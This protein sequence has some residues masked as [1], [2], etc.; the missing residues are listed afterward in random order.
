[1][2]T[3]RLALLDYRAELGDRAEP[4]QEW[5]SYITAQQIDLTL[6]AFI[7]VLAVTRVQFLP[8][9]RFDFDDEG[10]PAAVCEVL[11]DDAETVIDL[12]AWSVTKPEKFGVALGIAAGLG[13]DQARNPA[14]FFGGQPLVIRRTPLGWIK[15]GCRGAVILSRLLAPNWLG[16]AL[17]NIAGEDLEHARELARL[18]HPHVS[19]RRIMAPLPE[20]A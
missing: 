20:A 1:M 7:G 9:H 18:L 2:I 16:T 4:S 15:A 11:D 8:L 5:K 14:T 19:P 13:T 6:Y 3:R 12:V 10:M 17:G